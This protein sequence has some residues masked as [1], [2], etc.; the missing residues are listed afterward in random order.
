MILMKAGTNYIFGVR[1]MSTHSK[2]NHNWFYKLHR[3]DADCSSIQSDESFWR[4]AVEYHGD[5]V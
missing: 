2:D 5:D 4:D 1:C 3:R